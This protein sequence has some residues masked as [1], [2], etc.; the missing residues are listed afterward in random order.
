MR[1]LA[2]QVT[3]PSGEREK[4]SALGLIKENGKPDWEE[5]PQEE[6]HPFRKYVY[7]VMR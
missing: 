7:E 4:H 3:L 1:A 2:R 5:N 6:G